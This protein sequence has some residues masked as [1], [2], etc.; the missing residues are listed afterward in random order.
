MIYE[1]VIVRTD[2]HKMGKHRVI[3]AFAL[4]EYPSITCVLDIESHY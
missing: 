4:V 2:V 3:T 1:S